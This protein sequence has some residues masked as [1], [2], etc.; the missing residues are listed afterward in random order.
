MTLL[1]NIKK[2][3]DGY[4]LLLKYH[5]KSAVRPELVASLSKKQALHSFAFQ[6]SSNKSSIYSKLYHT[7]AQNKYNGACLNKAFF[8]NLGFGPQRGRVQE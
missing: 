2:L 8:L 4:S 7:A 6:A 3:F 5:F 1:V